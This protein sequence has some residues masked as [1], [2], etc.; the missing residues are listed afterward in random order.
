MRVCG[1]VC[2]ITKT[3]QKSLAK[4]NDIE[5]AVLF[6]FIKVQRIYFPP[7]YSWNILHFDTHKYAK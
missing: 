1:V 3:R 7:V 5:S 2:E 4:S 6:D